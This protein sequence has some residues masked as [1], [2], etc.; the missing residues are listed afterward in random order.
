MTKAKIRG[1][2]LFAG[3]FLSLV[4]VEGASRLYLWNTQRAA[5]PGIHDFFYAE[6]SGEVRIKPGVSAWHKGLDGRPV[7]IQINSQGFRGP[8]IKKNPAQRIVFLGDSVV[9][10]GGVG[11]EETFISL[12]EESFRKDGRDVEIING[13]TTDVGVDQYALQVQSDRLR[14]LKPDLIAVGLFLNDSRPPQ[15]HLGEVKSDAVLSVL[16]APLVRSLG[17]ASVIRDAYVTYQV[18]RGNWLTNRFDWIRRFGAGGWIT[19]LPELKQTVREARYDWGAAWEDSFYDVVFPA[20]LRIRDVCAERGIAV[21]VV[22]FPVSLQVYTEVEDSFI[23]LPQRRIVEFGRR[24]DIPVLDLLA[25]LRAHGNEP[26]L[27]DQAHLNKLG[28]YVVAGAIYPFLNKV[29]G[30]RP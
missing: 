18:R 10:N 1:V 29:L 27:A 6:S 30:D 4:V 9:F 28:N 3:I 19:E 26:V 24:E 17:T 2:F 22:V 25:A 16:D 8:E 21:A 14:D 20:L 5:A 12:I 7:K 11:Q 13:G 15:G 23:V